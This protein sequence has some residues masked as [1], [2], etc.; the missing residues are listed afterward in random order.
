M[1]AKA[2][3]KNREALEDIVRRLEK[4]EYVSFSELARVAY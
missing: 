2:L 4:G 3:I 1:R